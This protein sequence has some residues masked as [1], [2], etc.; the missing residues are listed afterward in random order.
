MRRKETVMEKTKFGV[1]VGLVAAITYLV[2]M[3]GGYLATIVIAGY[4]LIFEENAFLRRSV[5]KALGLLLASSLLALVFAF[6]PNVC[7]YISNIVTLSGGFFSYMK[8][9]SVIE[10][11]TGIIDFAISALF[12]TLAGMA[13]T[14][15]KVDIPL[16]N[17]LIDKVVN[18]G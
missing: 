6:I 8:V 2:A 4:V 16:F 3:F 12:L 14:G 5:T 9:L 10:I 1:S 18:N 11:F 17:K 15:G 13:F 7:I